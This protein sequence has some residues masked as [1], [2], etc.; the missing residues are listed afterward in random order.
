MD[1][2]SCCQPMGFNLN[3]LSELS[4]TVTMVTVT[5]FILKSH[6]IHSYTVRP[7]ITVVEV[8]YHFQVSSV[9]IFAF[10]LAFAISPF[11][12]FLFTV[13]LIQSYLKLSA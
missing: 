1:I 3:F 2:C 8:Y 13:E 11:S 7:P 12:L 4:W 10:T 6:L 5:E 9:W